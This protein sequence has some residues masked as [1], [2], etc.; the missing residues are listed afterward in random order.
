MKISGSDIAGS[1]YSDNIIR[2]LSLTI[3]SLCFLVCWF[4]CQLG[5]LHK[6]GRMLISISRLALTLALA[7][8]G[9]GG[10]SPSFPKEK[11]SVGLVWA[12]CPFGLIIVVTSILEHRDHRTDNPVRS[13]GSRGGSVYKRKG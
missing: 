9:K 1:R 5:S 2:N 11:N 4:H 7:N 12:T 3:S 8:T 6:A 13:P 10:N